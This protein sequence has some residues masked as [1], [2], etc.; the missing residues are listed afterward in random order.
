MIG[1]YSGYVEI[2][3]LVNISEMF[4]PILLIPILSR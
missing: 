3:I 4:D 1:Y 2:S